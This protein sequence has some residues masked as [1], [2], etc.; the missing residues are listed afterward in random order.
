M[1]TKKLL[2][3]LINLYNNDKLYKYIK[4]GEIQKSNKEI[5]R[6]KKILKNKLLMHYI[7]QF[8]KDEIITQI[9][10][11]SDMIK[12]GEYNKYLD[13]IYWWWKNDIKFII[14]SIEESE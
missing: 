11:I 1:E 14:E 13:Q 4:N 6:I 7:D 9:E 8:G 2:K 3:V 5:I 10:V 12:H